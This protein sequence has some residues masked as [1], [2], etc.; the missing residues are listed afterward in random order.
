MAAGVR[1]DN[2][3]AMTVPRYILAEA[4]FQPYNAL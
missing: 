3:R 2:R 1:K 4:G